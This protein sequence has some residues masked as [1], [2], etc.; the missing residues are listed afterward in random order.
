MA[1]R[2][3]F[4]KSYGYRLHVW[5][6]INYICELWRNLLTTSQVLMVQ[7]GQGENPESYS[8]M[9]PDGVGYTKIIRGISIASNEEYHTLAFVSFFYWTST[10]YGTGM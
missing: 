5:Q 1:Q 2:Q 6:W 7:K 3:V 8:P 9:H 4:L 10:Y